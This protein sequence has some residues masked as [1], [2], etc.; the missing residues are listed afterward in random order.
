[1]NTRTSVLALV[2]ACGPSETAQRE[3]AALTGAINALT[4]FEE[5]LSEAPTEANG[6]DVPEGI[7]LA[8]CH[9]D[10]NPSHNTVF[11]TPEETVAHYRELLEAVETGRE[12]SNLTW[13]RER[14]LP[15]LPYRRFFAA[16]LPDEASEAAW[17]GRVVLWDSA[18]HRW[19]GAVRVDLDRGRVPQHTYALF[20]NQGNQVGPGHRDADR[21]T[22]SANRAFQA[23]LPQ[24]FRAAVAAG[25]NVERVD[26]V[27]RHRPRPLGHQLEEHAVVFSGGDD[28]DLAALSDGVFVALGT[29][30]VTDVWST[31]HGFAYRRAKNI[32]GPGVPWLHRVHE[33]VVEDLTF[34]SER[35]FVGLRT[36]ERSAWVTAH[37][38]QGTAEIAR[39]N[40]G[41]WDVRDLSELSPAPRRISAIDERD[42]SLFLLG[43]SAGG[44]TLHAWN[45]TTWTSFEV[46][47]RGADILAESATSVLVAS[48]EGLVRVTLPAGER[49]SLSRQSAR[50]LFRSDAG[51]WVALQRSVYRP[52]TFA[53]VDGANL[54]P[55]PG[56]RAERTDEFDLGPEGT[57]AVL[58]RGVLRLRRPDGNALRIPEEGA[59]PGRVRAF[60]I[61]A[62]GTVWIASESGVFVA[63]DGLYRLKAPTVP[64]VAQ[65]LRD[66]A[67]IGD[68]P[69]LSQ[70]DLEAI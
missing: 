57:L 45:G 65:G 14:T 12:L 11:V 62:H 49:T 31:E 1:M 27:T 61:D 41:D 56:V 3:A 22:A 68:G 58:S 67:I 34:Y 43:G 26:Q 20:D 19:L 8:V 39:W 54:R 51:T 53:Q 64:A 70:Q 21:D 4:L 48:S 50:R 9:L 18:E 60:Q 17:H 30:E 16:K 13:F 2:L 38:S 35:T 52:T 36:V 7:P 37:D 33:N 25:R 10:C 66:L 63:T 32:L 47:G 24:A 5:T 40:D 15:F 55:I 23:M 46:T 59:I 42:G 28:G 29:D 6:F 69:A 44:S